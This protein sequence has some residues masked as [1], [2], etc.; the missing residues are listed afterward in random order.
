MAFAQAM[1]APGE[2]NNVKATPEENKITLSWD[3]AS[4]E[5]GVVVGYKIYYGTESVQTEDDSYADEITVPDQTSYTVEGLRSRVQYFFALTALDDEENESETYS[6][7][8]SATPLAANQTEAPV[9]EPE[10]TPEPETTDSPAIVSAEQVSNTEILITM[11]KPVQL[12]GGNAS[13]IFEQKDTGREVAIISSVANGEMVTLTFT[14]SALDIGKVYTVTASSLVEDLNGQPV[15]SGITDTAEFTAQFF[16]PPKP[17]PP[18]PEPI[19]EPEPT[20]EPPIPEPT[21]EENPVDSDYWVSEQPH[22]V[23]PPQDTNPPLDATQLKVDASQLSSQKKVLLSWQGALDLENDISDQILFVR[24]G[25]GQWDSGL[26][27]G[28]YTSDIELDVEINQN[29]QIRI[30]TTDTSGNSSGGAVLSFSTNLIDSGPGGSIVVLLFAAFVG[31][32]LIAAS[33]RT[34]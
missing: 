10:S 25:L 2:V 3:E 23:A 29:Y 21:E 12:K 14:E 6:A 7:E 33:R 16:E 9:A 11:S 5:D 1:I 15:R 26:S 31:L 20:P 13:F 17:E 32:F 28:K 18:A 24:K 4:D 8:V 22:E 30:V 27:L 34:I 19:I